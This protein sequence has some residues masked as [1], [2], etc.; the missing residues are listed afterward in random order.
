[1]NVE[2]QKDGTHPGHGSMG[3]T[4]VSAAAPQQ[5]FTALDPQ[6]ALTDQLMEQICDPKNLI[7]AYRRV[8]A[9]KGKPGVDGMTV[10]ELADWLRSHH[11][12]ADGLRCWTGPTGPS[13]Y[14]EC[15]SASRKEVS[16]SWAFRWLWIAWCNR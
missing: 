6:R 14:G 15:N 7:R 1:M 13:P 2:Q 9:N 3:G 5:T 16:V 10:G 8:R 4:C 12:G 11:A